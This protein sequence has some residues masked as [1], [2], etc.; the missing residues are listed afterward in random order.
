MKLT[1]TRIV[2]MAASLAPAVPV[3][4]GALRVRRLPTEGKLL[5]GWL[6][7]TLS[8]NVAMMILGMRGMHNSPLA[9]FSLPVFCGVGLWALGELSGHPGYRRVVLVSALCYLLAWGA[10]TLLNEIPTEYSTYSQSLMNLVLISAATGLVVIRLKSLVLDPV[11]DPAIL[12]GLAVLV[13]FGPS[14]AIDPA[15]AVIA[16]SRPDLVLTLYLARVGFFVA[17]FFLYTLALL[18][19]PPHPSSSG[20]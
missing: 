12:T 11:R 5:L 13:S 4:L 2:L 14:V 15:A 10:L 9:H 6:S 1:A 18:W 3:T 16:Q 17:G 19:I 20:S 7:L 8:L